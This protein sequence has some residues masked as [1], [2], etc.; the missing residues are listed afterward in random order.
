[1]D[2][3]PFCACVFFS[4]RRRHT[5]WALVTGVH[6]CALPICPSG[7][8]YTVPQLVQDPQ[9]LHLGVVHETHTD[10]GHLV[11]V[12][13]QPVH[14]SRTPA[15]VAAAAPGWGNE[16]DDVLRA[17]ER[18]VGKACVSTFRSRG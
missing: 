2:Y 7:P 17:E 3:A 8:V 18:R 10:D 1:M 12:I 9:V 15:S 6:T 13:T 14:L 5:S 4:S 11:R 16:T